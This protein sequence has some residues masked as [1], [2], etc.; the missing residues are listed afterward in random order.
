[1]KKVIIGTLISLFVALLHS[2]SLDNN[3]ITPSCRIFE[4]LLVEQTWQPISGN[5]ADIRFKADRQMTVIGSNDSITYELYNCNKLDVTNHTQ[6]TF[7]TWQIERL[8]EDVLVLQ[9]NKDTKITFN[10]K[11]F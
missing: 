11:T 3:V 6:S 5:Q 1:M 8:V 7:E 10:R 4:A 9:V 2:C